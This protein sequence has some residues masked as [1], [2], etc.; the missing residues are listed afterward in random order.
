[1]IWH[2]IYG[3]AL[4]FLA[5]KWFETQGFWSRTFCD[6][7]AV[8]RRFV[9]TFV[10]M[11]TPR[12]PV[13][14]R[15]VYTPYS[16]GAKRARY[17]NSQTTKYARFNKR[18]SVPFRKTGTLTQQVKS[19]QRA[20]KA[21]EPELKYYDI[22]VG[23]ADIPATGTVTHVTNIAQGDTAGTRT[24]NAIC[25][26]ELSFNGYFQRN[27]TDFGAD[28]YYRIAIVVDKQQVADTA[29]T[30]AMIFSNAAVPTDGLPNVDNLERFRV[31]WLS[32]V[33]DAWRMRL[34]SDNLAAGA[35]TQSAVFSKTMKLNLRVEYNGTALTDIQ[36]N[37]IYVVYISSTTVGDISANIRLG[38]TDV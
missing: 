3:S 18:T 20:V 34:D 12:L 21:L 36:K 14:R 38:F 15:L 7:G 27:A 35:P 31:L 16:A 1:M 9:R 5:Q 17:S 23:A 30:A 24:G 22:S 2:Q 11:Y 25:V 4:I 32:P 19:L 26:K 10:I 8:F 13:R 37:G 29:P 28:A 6:L 33:Y